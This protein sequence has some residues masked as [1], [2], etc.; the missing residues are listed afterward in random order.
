MKERLSNLLKKYVGVFI[1]EYADYLSKEQLETLKKINY[2]DIIN[3]YDLSVPFGVIQYGKIYMTEVEPLMSNLKKMPNYNTQKSILH[4]QNLSSYLQYMCANGY[5]SIDYYED[6]LLYF[7]FFMVIKNNSGLIKGIINQEIRFL[8][9]KYSLRF[10][11]LF[12][13]EEKVVS[14]ITPVLKMDG[15][16]KI[17]F[18]DKASSFKYLNDNYGFRYATLVNHISDLIDSEFKLIN[19]KEYSGFNGFLDYV[20]DY[21][22]IYYV[23][24]YNEILDFE[25]QNSL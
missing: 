8:S 9:I 18:M 3:V 20:N 23:D 6:I 7:V 25:A 14:K 12:A 4:N 21:E 11:S 2:Q 10:A 13:R 5:D 19:E 22:R 17:L 16:R 15:C 24:A 1:N